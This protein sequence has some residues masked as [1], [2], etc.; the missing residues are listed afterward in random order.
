MHPQEMPKSKYAAVTVM[1]KGVQAGQAAVNNVQVTDYG[2]VACGNITNSTINNGASAIYGSST[3]TS[4]NGGSTV[5]AI[6]QRPRPLTT[7]PSSARCPP[8]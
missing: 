3:N 5:Y 2:I 6:R 7:L 4:F 1:G 8:R